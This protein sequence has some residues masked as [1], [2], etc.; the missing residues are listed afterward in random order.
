MSYYCLPV[1]VDAFAIQI[2]GPSPV[3]DSLSFTL[4]VDK[5]CSI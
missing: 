4:L 1:V 3:K 5:Q 2:E